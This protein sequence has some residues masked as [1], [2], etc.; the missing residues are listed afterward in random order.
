MFALATLAQSAPSLKQSMKPFLTNAD[1]AVHNMVFHI[2]AME[3]RKKNTLEIILQNWSSF[4]SVIFSENLKKVKIEK[5]VVLN[6]D[7]F[8]HFQKR[9]E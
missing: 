7:S 1:D 4:I 3:K 9:L 5:N 8:Y 2:R 6:A